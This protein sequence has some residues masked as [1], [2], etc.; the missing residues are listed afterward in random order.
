MKNVYRIG[1]EVQKMEG[2]QLP[3]DCAGA[4]VSVYIGANK[5]YEAIISVEKQLLEDRYDPVE[6]YEAYLLDLEEN[7][8]DTD[9]KG[10]PGNEDLKIIKETGNIWYGP[11]HTFP[12]E[13][14]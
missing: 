12:Y 8:Y 9:E 3:E 4:F 14:N 7:D 6:T 5:I 10:Y 13:E 1:V 2:T 11:F